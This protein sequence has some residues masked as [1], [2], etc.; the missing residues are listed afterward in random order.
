MNQTFK[1]SRLESESRCPDSLGRVTPVRVTPVRVTPVRVTSP[2]QNP[3]WLRILTHD[4]VVSFPLNFPT[5]STTLFCFLL[6]GGGRRRVLWGLWGLWKQFGAITPPPQWTNP[7]AWPV[8]N[9]S[10]CLN[11]L[12][13][14][15]EFKL[16]NFVEMFFFFCLLFFFGGGGYKFIFFSRRIDFLGIKRNIGF[17]FW[18]CQ[19]CPSFH[20]QV[21]IRVFTFWLKM[22]NVSFP[23]YN[24]PSLNRRHCFVFCWEEGG[25]GALG[26]LGAFES[27]KS[28]SEQSN[29]DVWI[30]FHSQSLN[31]SFHSQS[32]NPSFHSQVWIR[33]FTVKSESEFSQSSLNP[34]FHSQVWIRVFT[35]KSESEFSQPIQVWIRVFTAKVWIRVFT[36]KV[37]IRVFT[38]KVWIRVFTVKVRVQFGVNARCDTI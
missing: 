27:A 33:V 11:C 14:L 29:Q 10:G 30:R 31:P 23:W 9:Q 6:G 18:V 17:C 35:A 3:F 22:L 24:F 34:S 4:A 1:F 21:W 13:H 19:V 16:V 12:W 5:Q 38:V 7:C 8:L 15:Y 36:V 20:S 26:D 2:T 32:L 25:K 28:E 37:W